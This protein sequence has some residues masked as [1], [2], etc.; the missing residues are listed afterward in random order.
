MKFE[1]VALVESRI[2]DVDPGLA[3]DPDLSEF[4]TNGRDVNGNGRNTCANILWNNQ[5]A[6]L[7]DENDGH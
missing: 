6:L 5:Y 2:P 3:Q 7:A 4:V 1:F